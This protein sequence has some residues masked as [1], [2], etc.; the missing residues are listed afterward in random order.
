[1]AKL[2]FRIEADWQKVQK[3]REEISKL[4][5]EIKGTDV[6]QNPTAF[7]IL[8]AKLVQTSQELGKV[9]AKIIHTSATMET[10]FKQKIFA[11]SQS[12]NGFTEEIIKQKKIIA[13]TKD[14]IRTLSEQYR[15]MGKYEQSVSPIKTKLKEAK[16]ALAEQ[17]YSLFSLTQEQATARLSVKKLRDE[18]A[19]FKEEGGG[20][21]Q[22][23][24]LLTSKMKGFATTIIGGMGLKELASRIISVRA[25]FE[26]METSL[27]VL[28]GG[29]QERLNSIMGQIKEYALASPLNTK[30][31]VGAVQMMTSFGIEA[32][33]SIDYLKA[34]GDISMGDT[35]K[36]NSLAL[37]FS[38]MSS[39]G[40]LMGQDLMQM[41]NAGFNPLEEIA[42]KTGKSI[43][44]LKNEM[45]KGAI[46]SKMVQDAFI[47]A[48]S[49]GGK[50]FGMADE[51]SKT[52][53]GQISMLTESFDVMFNEIGQKGEGVVMTAVQTATKLV[54]NYERT[55][56]VLLGLVTTFG[57]YRTA[58]AVAT[59]TTNGY[60]LA[61][62]LAYTR[63]LL[64][65]KAQKL[66]N[67]T[68][69][70]NPYV[71]AAT[72][73]GVLVGALI[74]T[75]DSTTA[76]EDALERYN[77]KIKE[78]TE[79]VKTE[80]EE[81]DKLLDTL[82]NETAS[83]ESKNIAFNTLITK[84]PTIFGKY[85]TEK[86][87]IDNLTEARRLENA[88]IERKTNLLNQKTYEESKTRATELKRLAY[89][90]KKGIVQTDEYKRLNEKYYPEI[91]K[92]ANSSSHFTYQ[93]S[94]DD[95]ALSA[96]DEYKL[97]I[98]E[99]RKKQ[100]EKYN[101]SI[102]NMSKSQAEKELKILRNG[103]KTMNDTGKDYLTIG[104]KEPLS[105]TQ[106]K[107]RIA[108]LENN[109]KTE[110]KTMAQ[111]LKDA[112]KETKKIRK[113]AKDVASSKE[114]LT[115]DQA[116]KKMKASNSKLATAEKVES[117]FKVKDTAGDKKA[118]EAEKERN[119]QIKDAK[120]HQKAVDDL[121]NKH[122][123]KLQSEIELENQL[124]QSRID[125]MQEVYEKEKAQRELNHKKELEDIEKR[126][127][128]FLQ[129]KRDEAKARFEADPKNKDKFF[130]MS[131]VTLS[132]DEQGKFDEMRA[133]TLKKHANEERDY[134]IQ[135]I[136]ALNDYLKEYGSFEE[137]KLAITQEYEEKI[138]KA[139]S[140][141]E[142][143]SLEMQRDK[144]IEK[145]KND[146]LQ[147]TIDWNGIF[148]DLQG[149]T[150][151]YLQGLRNQLQELL[152]TGNL[153]IDQM[154]VISE[155]INAIDDELGK[156]QGIWDYV[157][158]KAREHNR[159]LKEA[160][161]AQERLNAARSEEAGAKVNLGFAKMDV[162]KYLSDAG[163]DM[164]IAD[165][166]TANL[167]GKIDLTDDKFK[168]MVPLLQR[169]AVAEG[170]L[171]D[172][173]KKTVDATNEARQAEDKAEINPAQKIADWFSDAQKF[174]NGKGID[175]LPDLLGSVGL[176][177]A[178]NK[179]GK[180]LAG[181][182]SAAGAAADFATGNYI[183][184]AIKAIDAVSNFG[185]A[186]FGDGN[187]DSLE[188]RIED[189]GKSNEILAKSIDSLAQNINKK[190]A[191]NE[192][193]IDA[194]KKALAAQKEIEA[195]QREQISAR[196]SE[197]SKKHSF[198]Y[199]A[200]K[201]GSGWFGWRDFN[202]VLSEHGHD[203]K[204]MSIDDLWQL[205]PE[206]MKLLRDN[207]YSAWSDLLNNT[208][209]QANPSELINEYINNAGKKE[210]L[211]SSLNEKLTGY[212]WDGFLNSYKSLLKNLE[213]TTE[214]FADNINEM[215]SNALIESFVNEE[216][217]PKIKELYDYI[218]NAS[219]NGLSEDEINEIRKR[220][221][222][223]AKIGTERRDILEQAGMISQKNASQK[224]SANG[225]SSITFEQANNIVALTTAGNISRDQ[226][227]DLLTAKL[228]TMDA[229]MRGLHTLVAEHKSIAD[230]TR[231]ILANSY[232][233]LQGIHE[234][235]TSMNK[236][237]KSIGSDMSDIK[238]QL[239]D[240]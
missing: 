106:I 3:L 84:Y 101:A 47:S 36:F 41:V 10:N 206:M 73:L 149:H 139:G 80:K 51:G 218:S 64:L 53:N 219:K 118:K 144:E 167:N 57:I 196:A 183:G 208:K 123:A 100:I 224:A 147:N 81:I 27:K 48:T 227:K 138:R 109:I 79:S 154:Q 55:G 72:A 181:F 172:A 214:D 90:H 61:E 233:E 42:R 98:S 24:D 191:T 155:K 133:N 104:D 23:M 5:Q 74:A 50:F 67:A 58:V 92:N 124:E 85:K 7:N 13:D 112:E 111:W 21:A 174:I 207:A 229:S 161:D 66:L 189:L 113:D 239:K 192:Q 122:I 2:S 194:Y 221:D 231:T 238:R 184:A 76:A 165:I 150:R 132:A 141:G 60:T 45:S 88:E 89:L 97:N 17:Q 223:I 230:E 39:A 168:G 37:A 75:T 49:A 169:L 107:E 46:S 212:S 115:K 197:W 200:N 173:R 12:V 235:T 182:N 226:I 129:R 177:D 18:Y 19:L 71:L 31:M 52:L 94:L 35:G 54:E 59:M 162:Q 22:T 120:A 16:D 237:L 153:P 77:A 99:K 143:A 128:D 204:I 25:E 136:Q 215:I 82:Q 65:E 236:T 87:L 83:I 163:V 186:I 95:L 135:Q 175:Q 28:L 222:D 20:T 188:K 152:N 142:K 116:E 105:R 103:L 137:K 198:N 157:G 151:Q 8:N 56:R 34:I 140:V 1:M 185:S 40:K 146:D 131:S 78:N 26:S 171:T 68:M 164:N 156:Q 166:S 110:R 170:K 44:E 15:S 178:G 180:G 209:G 210:E 176:S 69:L 213:S 93:S 216:L 228:S 14:E 125:A 126:R 63:M 225:V 30:D 193:S 11:A 43:G 70:A 119:K 134:Q 240:M 211:T 121:S 159:L 38:Q 195:N 86:E 201:K 33:K 217:Q 205:S 127:R 148:S 4:K 117:N 102:G 220:N 234:D 199:Y 202:K 96:E 29:N 190:D 130:N 145:A 6:I 32:E 62:T 9:E 108:L 187:V 203:K 114:L 160:A 91:S 179:I 158:E 232:L